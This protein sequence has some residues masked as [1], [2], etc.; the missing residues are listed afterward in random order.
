MSNINIMITETNNNNSVFIKK[1]TSSLEIIYGLD[2]YELTKTLDQ[3][4]FNYKK[5]KIKIQKFRHAQNSKLNRIHSPFN[6]P[7]FPYII[8][9]NFENFSIND[10]TKLIVIDDSHLFGEDLIDFVLKYIET[11]HI[12][13]CG[14][15]DKGIVYQLIPY[16]ER[17]K[18]IDYSFKKEFTGNLEIIYGCMKSGKTTLL[19]NKLKQYTLNN[20]KV[21]KIIHS[22]DSLRKL[23]RLHNPLTINFN[24]IYLNSLENII[25]P[26]DISIIGI[27]ECQFF[28][29]SLIHFVKNQLE[30]GKTIILS[31]LDGDFKRELFGNVYKLIPYCDKI[32]KLTAICQDCKEIEENKENMII[33]DYKNNIVYLKNNI[34]FYAYFSRRNNNSQDQIIVGDGDIYSPVCRSHFY[35]NK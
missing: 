13:L 7:F 20:K 14:L 26:E 19:N 21:I 31:G 16:C 27:D 8:K 24:T 18:K 22:L 15:D 25:I 4:L 9:E 23:D 3:L 33:N 34:I 29:E 17:I 5:D 2:E 12:I 6:S 35:I 10:D 11:K 30:L 32:E 28:D 1:L